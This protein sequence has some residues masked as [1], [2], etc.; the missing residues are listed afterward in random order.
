M[1]FKKLWLLCIAIGLVCFTL[2]QCKKQTIAE[3]TPTIIQLNESQVT[4]SWESNIPYTGKI[5]YKVAG[6]KETPRE[7]TDK[8][9]ETTNH[10]VELTGLQPSTQ[11]SYWVDGM[12][13][14]YNF[15]TKPVQDA[16]FSF[17]VTNN[18]EEEDYLSVL[19]SEAASFIIS[20]NKNTTQ[21][22]EKCAPYVPVFIVDKPQWIIN[23]GGLHLTVL[24][25][26]TEI[27]LNMAGNHTAGVFVF[28]EL[29]GNNSIEESNLHL[30]LKAHN[31]QVGN[32]KVSFVGLINSK[33]EKE[34]IDGISYVGLAQGK[35]NNEPGNYTFF[36]NVDIESTSAYFV[37][38]EKEILLKEPPLQGKRTCQECRRLADKGAYEQSIKAYTEFIETNQGHYQ[39]DDAYFAIAELYDNKLF[40]FQNALDWYN[41]LTD[42]FPE[43]N[44]VPLVN[45][46]IKYITKYNE[47]NFEPLAAF[48]KVKTYEFAKA[49]NIQEEQVK[50]LEKLDKII[51]QYPETRLAPVM[52]LWMANQYQLID[53]EKAVHIYNS[54]RID[55]ADF[56]TENEVSVK[57]G[58]TYYK[59]EEWKKAYEIY[60]IVAQEYPELNETT[61]SQLRRIK[62]NLK[63]IQRNYISLSILIITF[64]VLLLLPKR[65]YKHPGWK[66]L[67]IMYIINFGVLFFFAWMYREEFASIKEM[68]LL[69]IAFTV[70]ILLGV[71]SAYTFSRKLI[72]N[73]PFLAN[74]AGSALGILIF[75]CGFYQGIY[76]IYEHYLIAIK[77]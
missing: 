72:Q 60:T 47:A 25:K 26:N 29:L 4:I 30:R 75:L 65:G 15:T 53:V 64:L 71:I 44:L 21:A 24:T 27:D 11:Y 39:V 40:Q 70:S 41:N 18:S 74:L 9:G 63:R 12:Q 8:L 43:S 45:Q 5:L 52:K 2:Y 66:T 38:A 13:N 59:N 22:L 14:K 7:I 76:N 49:K 48:E 31:S 37:S 6:T 69:I 50:V 42:N 32:T 20:L 55:Y 68:L 1:K 67:T 51:K 73:K 10:E 58:E 28:S 56:S 33:K 57:I 34:K 36:V 35:G 19:K 46:R 77:W 61:S 62:R 17:I 54:I 16:V 3:V 23:W